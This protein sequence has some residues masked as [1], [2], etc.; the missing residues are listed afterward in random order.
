MRNRTVAASEECGEDL[1]LL[2]EVLA[3]LLLNGGYLAREEGPA[4]VEGLAEGV[5][6]P[7][8]IDGTV[9]GAEVFEQVACRFAHAHGQ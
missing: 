6:A 5:A 4:H 3:P 8:R 2:G 9:V 7:V 1:F